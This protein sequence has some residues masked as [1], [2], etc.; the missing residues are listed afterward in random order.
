MDKKGMNQVEYISAMII[1]LFGVVVIIYFALSFN[2]IQ[3]KDYLTAVENNLRKEI[4]ITYSKYYVS[5]NRGT[6]LIISS[7]AIP[8]NIVNNP[9]NL[10]ILDS[11]GEEKRF[12]WNGNNLAVEKNNG[13]YIFIISPNSTPTTGVNCDEQPTTPNF[14]LEEKFKAISFDKLKEFQEN[15]STNYEILKEVVAE[16]KNFNLEV[17]PCL[18]FKGMTVSRHIPKNVEVTAGEFPVKLFITPK[19]ICDVKVTI[20]LWD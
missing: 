7:E 4:E 13:Q 6:C 19:I 16:N 2:L 18:I 3:H 14:S 17:S 20:K 1:F 11:Q 5:N 8:K 15:Y 12:Q 10:T 9:N